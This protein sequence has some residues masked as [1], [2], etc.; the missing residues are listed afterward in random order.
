MQLI[1]GLGLVIN[2]SADVQM[3]SG[4]HSANFVTSQSEPI[5]EDTWHG[6]HLLMLVTLQHKKIKHLN[7]IWQ[8]ITVCC[9]YQTSTIT[10]QKSNLFRLIEFEPLILN[11]MNN[12]SNHLLTPSNEDTKWLLTL[13]CSLFGHWG[14]MSHMLLDVTVL[15]MCWLQS[16]ICF[17][18]T[19]S[20]Y[21]HE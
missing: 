15:T 1:H 20:I 2:L 3:R 12:T 9:F 13:T 17:L 14:Y 11:Q 7:Q 18:P 10:L 6:L 5:E 8:K 21:F 4:I 19:F 16:D